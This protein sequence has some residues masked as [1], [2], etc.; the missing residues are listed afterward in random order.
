[1]YI[2]NHTSYIDTIC[3]FPIID[4][5]YL[6]AHKMLSGSFIRPI[7]NKVSHVKVKRGVSKNTIKNVKNII[8]KKGSILI[9]P[10]GTICCGPYLYKFRSGAFITGYPVQP[11]SARPSFYFNCSS[12]KAFLNCLMM[13]KK[14]EYTLNILPLEYPPFTKEKIE[15]I[16]KKMADAS[17]L[18]LSRISSRTIID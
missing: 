9:Y 8:D 18:Q 17:D 16:R 13:N 15:S 12:Y 2:S 1:V 7:I 10:E 6:G 14:F 11:M 3:S 5:A 4:T